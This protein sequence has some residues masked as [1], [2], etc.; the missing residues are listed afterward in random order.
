MNLELIKEEF[1]KYV[2][3]FDMKNSNIDY[4]YRHSY[5]VYK[6]CERIADDLKLNDED[7]LLASIIGLLHDIGRFE[8]LKRYSHYDDINLD[9]AEYGANL[10]FK[11]N[12]IDKFKINEK[13]YDII[14]FSIRNHNKY[15]IEKINDKRKLLFAK[16]VRDADKIDIIKAL[17]I[18][19]DLKF[20]DG[21]DNI[22]YNAS[23]SFFNNKQII[24][25]DKKSKS[26]RVIGVLSMVFD[27]NID[28]A[29]KIIKDEEL[30]KNLYNLLENKKV[31]ERYFEYMNE[32]IKER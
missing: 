4:K 15:S 28:S 19:K 25:K 10:L 5:R 7:I 23:K 9:H 18:Y 27:I 16:I 20:Q 24:N 3:S 17:A 13:Y 29:I 12:L 1:D 22:S 8:Q 11:N 14:E 31:F 6:L 26:D 32:Y 21:F 2:K 30:I